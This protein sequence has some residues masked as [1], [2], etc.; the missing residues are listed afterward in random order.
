VNGNMCCGIANGDL[1]LRVGAENHDEVMSRPHTRAMDFTGRPMRGMVY[2]GR[3]G[4]RTA[5]QLKKW[6]AVA[7]SFVET[8]PPKRAGAKAAARGPAGRSGHRPKGKGASPRGPRRH[9]GGAGV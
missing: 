8:L 5:A 2:I 3:D 4:I 1:M 7:L 6:I 9:N